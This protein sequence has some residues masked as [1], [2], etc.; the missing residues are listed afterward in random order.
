MPVRLLVSWGGAL[1]HVVRVS[2]AWSLALN[3]TIHEA[4]FK[5]TL[6]MICHPAR[7]PPLPSELH[8]EDEAGGDKW[9]SG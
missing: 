5:Y 4:Q 9:V 3:M 2:G 6:V 7:Y 8:F 1:H